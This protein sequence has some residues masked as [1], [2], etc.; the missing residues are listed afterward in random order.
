MGEWNKISD[1]G[2]Q[3]QRTILSQTTQNFL[4]ELW[5]TAARSLPLGKR[6]QIISAWQNVDWASRESIRKIVPFIERA[7]CASARSAFSVHRDVD[8]W[9][10]KDGFRIREGKLGEKPKPTIT[11]DPA[12]C[13]A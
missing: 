11:D 2:H 9:L 7:Y 5:L 6:E 4:L 12:D 1:P 13:R 10:A 8:E 3:E